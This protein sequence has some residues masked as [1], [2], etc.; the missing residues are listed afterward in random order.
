[1]EHCDLGPDYWYDRHHEGGPKNSVRTLAF[2]AA[3]PKST[4]WD[5]IE[6]GRQRMRDSGFCDVCWG[7]L[8]Q[9]GSCSHCERE[10]HIDSMVAQGFDPYMPQRLVWDADSDGQPIRGTAKLVMF[11]LDGHQVSW[12]LQ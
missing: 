9:D 2:Y 12:D 1:M 11:T 5:W 3:V 8:S 7:G 6:R 4:M 10:K